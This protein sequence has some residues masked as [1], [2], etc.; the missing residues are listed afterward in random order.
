MTFWGLERVWRQHLPLSHSCFR[1]LYNRLGPMLSRRI[2][3]PFVADMVYLLLKPVEV[4]G[5]LGIE[6][7]EAM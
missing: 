5:W 4:L 3:T 6:S 7:P 1:A 2:R